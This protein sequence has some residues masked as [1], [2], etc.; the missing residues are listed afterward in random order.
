MEPQTSN[1]P[2]KILLPAVVAGAVILLMLSIA[3]FVKKQK[4]PVSQ[5]L[6]TPAQK[7]QPTIK[8]KEGMI[9]VKI[10]KDE[11]IPANVNKPYKLIISSTGLGYDVVGYDV[12]LNFDPGQLE[13]T[14]ATSLLP[15]FTL[16]KVTDANNLVLTGAKKPSAKTKTLWNETDII[17]LTVSPKKSGT[18]TFSILEKKDKE[19]TKYVDD[20]SAIHY[21]QVNS[22]NIQVDQ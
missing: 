12:I 20:A 10:S 22:I 9:F 15:E 8:P 11:K 6:P 4:L 2:N 18:I 1:N 14:R 5:N 7:I 17:S 21:P 3:F 16:F 19:T 13:I